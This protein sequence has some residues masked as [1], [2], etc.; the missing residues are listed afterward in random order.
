MYDEP[1]RLRLF[2]FDPGSDDIDEVVVDGGG[3]DA[4]VEGSGD[5]NIEGSEFAQ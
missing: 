4:D 1:T 5:G 3:M 2:G